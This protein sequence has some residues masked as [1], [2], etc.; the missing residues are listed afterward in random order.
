MIRRKGGIVGNA[1]RYY[2]ITL[3][4]IA[5]FV[6]LGIYGLVKMPKQEFPEYTIRQGLVVGVYPGATSSQVEQRLA[7]PLEE[8]MFTYPEVNRE[9]SYSMSK[10]GM[11]Y[12]MIELNDDVNNKDEVWSKIKL[13]LKEFKMTLPKEVIAL[14]AKDDFG[15]T[16]ALLITVESTDK[17][18]RELEAY[19]ED[20]ETRL[21][22]LPSVS[23]VRRYGLQQEQISVVLDKDRIASYGLDPKAFMAKVLMQDFNVSG[24]TTGTDDYTMPIYFDVSLTSEKEVAEQ[25]IYSDGK[26]NM[27]R[28]KDIAEVK[29]CY[30]EPSSYIT[31]NGN[32]AIVLSMEMRPGKNIVEY[33]EEVDKVLADFE[34]TIPESVKIRRVADQPKVVSASVNSFVR[35]LFISIAVVIL[36]MMLLFPFRSAVVAATS[37][38]VSIFISLAVMYLCNIPLNTVTLAALIAALGM[39]VDNSIIVVDAYLEKLDMGMSRWNAA[40]SSATDYFWSIFLATLCICIIFFPLL[41][42]LDGIMLDFLFMFPWTI[43]ITL[44]SSLV[45]AMVFIPLMEYRIIKKGLH[46]GSENGG[47]KK[48]FNLLDFVQRRYERLLDLTFRFPKATIAIAVAAIAGCTVLLLSL[49][50]RMLPY[51]DRDQFAVEIYL[52]EGST[53]DRTAAVCDSL[54]GIMKKDD[55]IL[56]VTSFVGESSPRF[57]ATYAPKI[58]GS[59][60]AQFIVNTVSED[61]T[62][63]VIDEYTVKYADM[64]PGAYVKFKQLDYQVAEAPVE[65]RFSGDNLEELKFVADTAMDMMKKMGNLGWVRT[66]MAEPVP[67]ALVRLDNDEASLLGISPS[68]VA[69]EISILYGGLPVGTVWEG[70]Y[71]IPVKVSAVTEDVPESDVN[72]LMDEYVSTM[73]PGVSVPLR[74]VADIVPVWNDGQIVRRNGMRSVSVLAEVVRGESVSK[75]QERVEKMVDNEIRPMLSDNVIVS[76]GGE[77]EVTDTIMPPIFRGLSASVL[78]VFFFLLFNFKKIGLALAALS[79]IL[80]SIIGTAIGLMISGHD[81]SIT[82]IL[83]VIGLIG[84]VVRN[85]IIMFEHAQDLRLNK[86]Y[87][88]RDAAYDAGKRRMLPIFLTSATT[89]FG[90]IPMIISNTSLWGPMGVVIFS[91]TIFCTLLAVTVLPV[92]YWKIFPQKKSSEEEKLL[93]A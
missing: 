72:P 23:N 11:V 7:K 52:A 42:T 18:Y 65:V 93:T 17:T 3:L 92:F 1:M 48:K 61:A 5:I 71:A 83:G 57:Q 90:V 26:G 36:V 67:A 15:D 10:N 4:I 75:A 50:Q 81:F 29:R 6:I 51:A 37:I 20:L 82:C 76:Y 80:F 84:V 63:D 73:I 14:I 38:P 77:S 60:Y 54:Y 46:S 70:D 40:I 59:N 31:N 91:G 56:S 24:G 8:F 28:V 53:L 33:G 34:K 64:F 85:A 68:M 87:S 21:K 49:N 30:Q 25:V 16:S 79:S 13:G 41:I 12:F 62:V 58:G 55:R 32:R 69:S 9:R 2:Q 44:M 43:T 47:K 45:V 22:R 74:Q 78:I 89:A 39:L 19:M 88:P 35:D 86:G 66:N 27:I